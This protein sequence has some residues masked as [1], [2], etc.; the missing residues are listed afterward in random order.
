VFSART[1]QI[2]PGDMP[3][4]QASGINTRQGERVIAGRVA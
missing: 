1:T 3:R 2:M 4:L